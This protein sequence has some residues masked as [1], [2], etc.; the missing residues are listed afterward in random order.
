MT[1]IGRIR[2]IIEAI[3]SAR[4]PPPPK[5]KYDII[6]ESPPFTESAGRGRIRDGGVV[7][8]DHADQPPESRS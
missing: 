2:E 4:F 6:G 5:R 3:G 8:K 1:A 7:N